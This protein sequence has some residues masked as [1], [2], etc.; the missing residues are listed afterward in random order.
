LRRGYAVLQD[1]EGH[2]LTSVTDA[3]A[4]AAVTARV[5]DG[6]FH[7]EI[8]DTEKLDETLDRESDA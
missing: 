5:A 4:G 8:T 6:R 3:A 7:A 2:V 1:A